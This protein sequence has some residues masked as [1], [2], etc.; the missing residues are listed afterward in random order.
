[1]S[2]LKTKI[3]YLLHE[4]LTQHHQ[5]KEAHKPG[6]GWSAQGGE[7]KM[8]VPAPPQNSTIVVSKCMVG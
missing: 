5:G 1:M 7:E 8:P 2:Y 6:L 4:D 3:K